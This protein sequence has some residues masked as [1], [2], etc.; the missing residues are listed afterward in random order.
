MSANGVTALSQHIKAGKLRGLAV[1]SQNRHPGFPD[2]PT[3]K[4]L[5]HP[6]ANFT[7]WQGVF[8]PAGIPESILK[9]LTSTLE[10]V[11]KDPEVVQSATRVGITLDY[12]NPEEFRQFIAEETK[13]LEKVAKEVNLSKK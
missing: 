13:V 8:A 3:T 9:V 5:G 12:K 4:E 7:L 2:I 1:A 11:F 6:Y 10:S